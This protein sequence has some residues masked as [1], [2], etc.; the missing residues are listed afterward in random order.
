MNLL[1]AAKQAAVS[2][3]RHDA[4]TRL[5]GRWLVFARAVW[6]ALVIP[7]IRLFVIATMLYAPD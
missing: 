7:S 1:R 5:Y 3:E 4:P 6:L 2:R